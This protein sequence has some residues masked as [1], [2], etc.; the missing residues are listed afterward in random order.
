MRRDTGDSRDAD[1][2]DGDDDGDDDD[3]TYSNASTL[4]S[5]LDFLRHAAADPPE[6]VEGVPDSFLDG[7]ERVDRKRL[8][9]GSCPIC[10]ERFVDD[11]HPLVVR[12]P[13]HKDHVFDME[14]IRPWLKLN[15]TCPLDRKSL[16]EKKKVEPRVVDEE[17]DPDDYF[18]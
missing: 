17:D 5:M 15:P 8:G 10:G 2:D 14:C 7:L 18:A 6:K 4:D 1:N 3:V 9:D 12:L 13:C 11:P 16:V